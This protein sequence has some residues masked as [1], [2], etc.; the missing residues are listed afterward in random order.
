MI[1]RLINE[2]NAMRECMG[3][4]LK[5]ENLVPDI[6]ISCNGHKGSGLL[7]RPS[8]KPPGYKGEIVL[9]KSLYAPAGPEAYLGVIHAL[10]NTKTLEC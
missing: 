4:L 3:R 10:S 6:I 7:Q 2:A 8:L 1:G 5:K 9:N